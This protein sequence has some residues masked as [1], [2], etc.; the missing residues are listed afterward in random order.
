VDTD[1]SARFYCE[2]FGAEELPAP[3]FGTSKP[4]RW[5]R[6]GDMQLHLFPVSEQ[7]ARTEQHLAFEVDDFEQAYLKLKELGILTST[8]GRPTY[9]WILPGGQLQMYFRD[10]ADNLVEVNGPD[11]ELL[12]RSVFGDQLRELEDDLPQSEENQKAR[13]FLRDAARA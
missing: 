3:N 7:P 6:I 13:L 4:V 11:V 12:D 5:L 1:A 9:V 8:V 2:V 10:P